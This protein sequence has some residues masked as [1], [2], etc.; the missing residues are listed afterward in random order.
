MSAWDQDLEH[1]RELEARGASFSRNRD[2]AFYSRPSHRRARELRRFLRS[3]A[4]DI[5]QGAGRC[6][7]SVGENNDGGVDLCIQ[8]PT[9]GT[10]RRVRMSRAE[11][12]YIAELLGRSPEEFVGT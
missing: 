4:A 3:I 12:S 11:M 9:M 1:L 2:F 5:A 10:R 7:V 6:T 8:D